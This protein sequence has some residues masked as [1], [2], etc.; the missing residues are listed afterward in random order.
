M[1][2][3]LP[4]PLTMTPVNVQ[5]KTVMTATA[6][7]GTVFVSV[8]SL[9]KATGKHVST[10][11]NQ[12]LHFTAMRGRVVF[13]T[14]TNPTRPARRECL[15]SV[16]DAIMRVTH[17]RPR[18]RNEFASMDKYAMTTILTALRQTPPPVPEDD[19]D[20]PSTAEL[21]TAD[22]TPEVVSGE[23]QVV[24]FY[25]DELLALAVNDKAWV[26]LRRVC[27]NLGVAFDAQ[28]V[29]LKNKSASRRSCRRCK[30]MTSEG[31]TP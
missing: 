15:V 27:E 29:K 6:D 7:D 30:M 24:R 2:A 1:T 17:F 5:D 23:L 10:T 13:R 12:F 20:T 18:S 28:R 19:D 21:M 26:S 11:V 31:L 9:A 22:S 16:D 14:T 4:E 3:N 8:D 25:D